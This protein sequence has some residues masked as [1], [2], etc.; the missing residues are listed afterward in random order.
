MKWINRNDDTSNFEDRRG[1][2]RPKKGLAIGTLGGIAIVVI[3]LLLGEDPQ[4]M[5]RLAENLSGGSTRGGR[6]AVSDTKQP[7]A[8]EAHKVFTLGVFNSCND[9]WKELFPKEFGRKYKKPTLV[10]FT[11]YTTSGCGEASSA[12]GPF[13][14]SADTRVYIDLSF[15]NEL[16][17]RFKAPGDLA[18]AYVTAHEVGHHVQHLLGITDKVHAMR[19]QVSE[20]EYNKQSVR[21]E[22]QADFLAGVWAHQAVKQGTIALDMSDLEDA[23]RAAEAIGDDA[24]QRAAQGYVVPDAFTHGTSEQRMRW[25]RLGYTTG[26]VK[27]GDTFAAS[28]L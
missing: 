8:N 5:L 27:Q 2:G 20:V 17:T 11:D 14:C 15:F 3:A 19:G 18:M 21:L 7:K 22:L 28:K 10:A 12:V 16:A 26:D 1:G 9:V 23:L 6:T 25:F 4:K 13:Y 24:L